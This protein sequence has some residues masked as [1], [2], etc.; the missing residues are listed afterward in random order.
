MA[1]HTA[2][3][4]FG[5]CQRLIEMSGAPGEHLLRELEPYRQIGRIAGDVIQFVRIFRQIEQQWRQAAA[6]MDVFEVHGADDGE[7]ALTGADAEMAFRFAAGDRA[8]IELPM[9]GVAPPGWSLAIKPRRE[10][11]AVKMRL[12]RRIDR[13]EQRREDVDGLGETVDR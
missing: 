9:R 4:Q 8:E 3:C 11:S 1:G 12:R 10:R 7:I 13:F 5:Q 2:L 6:E